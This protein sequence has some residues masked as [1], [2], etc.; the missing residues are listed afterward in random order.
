MNLHYKLIFFTQ[1]LAMHSTFPYTLVL[2]IKNI[3]L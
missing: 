2:A 3:T 1:Y